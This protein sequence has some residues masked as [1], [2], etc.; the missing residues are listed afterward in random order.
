[1]R[2]SL[3]CPKCRGQRFFEIEKMLVPNYEFANSVEPFTLT[4]AYTET[5]VVTKGIFGG[6]ETARYGAEASAFVCAGCGYTELYARQLDVLEHFAS[7]QL[8]G[9]RV[10]EARPPSQGPNR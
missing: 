2:K 3:I 1:M 6:P 8:G 4:A 5:G 9:V 10:V 7:R